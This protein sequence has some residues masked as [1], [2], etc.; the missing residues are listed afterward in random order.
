MLPP[1]KTGPAKRLDLIVVTHRHE[2]HIK[3]FDAEFFE[4]IAIQNIWLSAAMDKSHKQADRT[5]G[6]A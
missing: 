6:A 4:N 3:G 1:S 5:H 2:D